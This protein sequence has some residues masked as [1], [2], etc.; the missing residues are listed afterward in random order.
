VR[1]KDITAVR[2]CASKE[3]I[4]KAVRHLKK[5]AMYVRVAPADYITAVREC[6]KVVLIST[7][8][9]PLRKKKTYAR[10]ARRDIIAVKECV[11]NV[12]T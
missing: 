1:K 12:S 3:S 10:A 5:K 2:E 4:R 8:V 9:M 7:D 6:A 11:L